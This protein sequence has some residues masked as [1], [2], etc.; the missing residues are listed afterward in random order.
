MLKTFADVRGNERAKQTLI[1]ALE[2]RTSVLLIGPPGTTK[3]ILAQRIAAALP[4][5]V[6]EA[7]EAVAMI[8]LGANL[9]PSR[10]LT[11]GTPPP[12]RA[13]HHTISREGLIG[14]IRT[15]HVGQRKTQRKTQ[16]ETQTVVPGE[17]SLAHNGVLLLDELPE[18]RASVFAE[19][20][21]VMQS[22]CVTLYGSKIGHVNIPARPQLVIATANPCPCGW[23][24]Y[25]T[26]KCLCGPAV[27]ASYNHRLATCA[28]AFPLH[29]TME[30]SSLC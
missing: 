18:F 2:T 19:A 23:F 9:R 22:G 3:T 28:K 24:G 4:V 29:A 25:T 16:R 8:Y 14:A 6:G 30:E 5:L 20:T 13:P 26:R 15:R 17:F 27:L 12:F 10:F 11:N 21:R 7:R 1:Q